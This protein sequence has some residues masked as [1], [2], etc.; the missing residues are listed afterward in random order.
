MV[1]AFKIKLAEIANDEFQTY[2]GHS[3]AG[4][5]LGPRIE[6]YWTDLQ[7]NFPGVKTPWSA[8]FVCWC[9]RKAG[10]TKDEFLFHPR[11]AVF[12]HWAIANEK[13]GTG[14][15]RAVRYDAAPPE[16]G[17][18]VHWNQPGG[19]FDFPHATTEDSYPSHSAIVVA[20]GQD[21]DGRFAMTI[22]GNENDS[23]GR[24]RVR[25]N[26]A[27]SIVQRANSPFISL[28]RTLK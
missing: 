1:S 19:T 13:A 8:A 6:T 22:G 3:E 10:A 9:L 28:V 11:H 4:G 27:G 14:L 23:V 21:D 17:D 18:L 25:L 12:V 26:I 15:F 2:G 20:L 5:V 16:V 24:T 7:W